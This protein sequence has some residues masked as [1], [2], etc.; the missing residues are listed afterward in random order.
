MNQSETLW[1]PD[2]ER[3]AASRLAAFAHAAEPLAGRTLP[4]YADLHAWSV[5][6]PGLFWGLVWDFCGIIGDKGSRVVANGEAMPG[7]RFFPDGR[8]N[9]AE[10]LLSKT[11]SGTA[12]RFLG[13]DGGERQLRHDELRDLVFRLAK[14]FLAHGVKPG[15]RIAAMLPNIPE[16][17][18]AMLAAA[19]IGA[20]WSSCSPDFGATGV[21]DRFAQIKPKIFL[22]PDGYFYNGKWHD[23]TGRTAEVAGAL[24]PA[25]TVVVPYDGGGLRNFPAGP[26]TSS[27]EQFIAPYAAGKFAFARFPFDHPL[28][29]L[30]TS[31]TTGPPKCIVHSA[32]GTLI[33]HLKEH[34]LHC[35]IRPGDPVFYFTTLGWM[36]WNWLVSSLASGATICLYD[37]SP[38]HPGPGVLF[39]YAEGADF[40]LFGTSAK[41]ID[42]LHKGGY[43]PDEHHRLAS[44]RTVCSTGSPLSSQSFRFVYDHIKRDVHLASISGGT[45]IVSC[46]VL[47]VP[48]LPV[49]AG[50]VQGPGLGMAVDVYSGKGKPLAKGKGELVCTKPFPS[51]PIGFLDDEDGSRYSKAYFTR[52]KNVWCHGDFAEWTDHGGM[53]IHGRSDATLNPGGVRIGTAEIYAQVEQLDQI[54][55]AVCVGQ[56]HEGDVRVILFVR[57]AA[58]IVLDR[59]LAK[60]IRTTIRQGTS[61]R[62]V[63]AAIYAVGDIPRTRSGKISELAVRDA[64]HGR[65][66][67]NTGALANP[68]ALSGFVMK[69]GAF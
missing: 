56:E 25:Q 57:L 16:A 65:G 20:V 62:H 51:M 5:A 10:N 69:G 58:G 52:F 28:A 23:V 43:F 3:M 49:R 18:A 67:P 48:T 45:D 29:I 35:D 36:M 30:F 33:Q 8:L 66:V 6:E 37:G 55:E 17:V 54:L 31:G 7:A 21:L 63:P 42:G 27:L 1:V 14:G 12:I 64:V 9:Y 34:Q 11:G 22:C 61:P 19:S 68:E 15:D 50:E 46:F 47:G 32:G 13:E 24:K 26:G 2:P 44:L 59:A 41:F 53:I 60:T 38:V 40:A 39:D 4:T